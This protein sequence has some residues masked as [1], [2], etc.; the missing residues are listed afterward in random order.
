MEAH[1]RNSLSG[2]SSPGHKIFRE[3]L[4]EHGKRNDFSYTLDEFGWELGV[5]SLRKRDADIVMGFLGDLARTV[6][7]EKLTIKSYDREDVPFARLKGNKFPHTSVEFRLA[8][9][10][11]HAGSIAHGA[12]ASSNIIYQNLEEYQGSDE[13]VAWRQALE[14]IRKRNEGSLSPQGVLRLEESSKTHFEAET[15]PKS[16]SLTPM[17]LRLFSDTCV[18]GSPCHRGSRPQATP[19]S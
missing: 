14:E 8:F 16:V 5:Y 9:M 7:A 3:Y 15:N 12:Q 18:P 2:V 13:Y 11:A 4:L 19:W 1:V 6:G 10:W 17:V